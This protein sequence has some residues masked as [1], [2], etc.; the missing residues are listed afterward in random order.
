[1]NVQNLMRL[2]N[3]RDKSFDFAPHCTQT[4]LL[5]HAFWEASDSDVIG[6]DSLCLW[7][8]GMLYSSFGKP[9]SESVFEKNLEV[10]IKVQL[11]LKRKSLL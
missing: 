8:H 1:M 10:D 2:L 4:K 11:T 3:A 5:P 9:L 7:K 6:R